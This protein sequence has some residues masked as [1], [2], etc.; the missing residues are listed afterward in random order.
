MHLVTCSPGNFVTQRS[1]P[2]RVSAFACEL[3]QD[4]IINM[5]RWRGRGWPGLVTLF[6]WATPIIKPL[7]QRFPDSLSKRVRTPHETCQKSMCLPSA[8]H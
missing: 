2:A 3:G 6:P 4:A 8:S 7:A 5:Q 1:G